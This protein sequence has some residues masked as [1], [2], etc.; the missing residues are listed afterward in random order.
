M[1]LWG[2]KDRDQQ[3]SS[4]VLKKKDLDVSTIRTLM[5]DEFGELIWKQLGLTGH[6]EHMKLLE[7]ASREQTEKLKPEYRI[8]KFDLNFPDSSAS[9][10]LEYGR[11]PIKELGHYEYEEIFGTPK[12][13]VIIGQEEIKNPQ[14]VAELWLIPVCLGYYQ[15]KSLKRT[16]HNF[17]LYSGVNPDFWVGDV[18]M[19]AQRLAAMIAMGNSS[20][21]A[22]GVLKGA[23]ALKLLAK[24]VTIILATVVFCLQL[25][26]RK[27]GVR[28]FYSFQ[29]SMDIFYSNSPLIGGLLLT[30]LF[31]ALWYWGYRRRPRVSQ[32]M[33]VDALARLIKTIE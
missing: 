19:L 25:F 13:R 29:E 4:Q 6:P 8:P 18:P 27:R 9:D 22:V 1:F 28:H 12:V 32:Y 26:G 30:L 31:V 20:S 14:L 21:L 15:T 17:F 3:W 10:A 2:K 33:D 24:F 5:P 7:Q 23:A 16:S 11:I